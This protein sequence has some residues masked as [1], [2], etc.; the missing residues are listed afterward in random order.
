MQGVRRGL[1]TKSAKIAL[2]VYEEGGVHDLVKA[3]RE[4]LT[5]METATENQPQAV[6]SA[7]V[8]LVMAKLMEAIGVG[9]AMDPGLVEQHKRV[10]REVAG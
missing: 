1:A 7:P 5:D 9:V 3:L 6:S 10:C 4:V 2:A 8:Q